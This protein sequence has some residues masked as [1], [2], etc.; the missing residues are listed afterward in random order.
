[1]PT[2]APREGKA[3]G[4]HAASPGDSG[5]RARRGRQGGGGEGR[6]HSDQQAPF[7]LPS[8]A[9][10][11]RQPGLHFRVSISAARG[12]RAA[13]SAENEAQ[14]PSANRR[15]R[16]CGPDGMGGKVPSRAVEKAHLPAAARAQGV[17][18]EGTGNPTEEPQAP[19]AGGGR[20]G[21]TPLLAGAQPSSP[22]LPPPTSGAP[23]ASPP[24]PAWPPGSAARV[25]RLPCPLPAL[26]PDGWP[27]GRPW[28]GP[29]SHQQP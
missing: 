26:R 27:M 12:W 5:T 15:P 10:Y 28:G 20:S 17:R 13:G 23:R 18:E 6:Q 21:K 8:T 2:D 9:I 16:V 19:L 25:P 11:Q 14:E 7:V 1:M 22:A 24:P 4:A 29:N 3:R